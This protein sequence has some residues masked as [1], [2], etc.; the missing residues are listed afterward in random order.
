MHCF[1]WI[2]CLA[3]AA[4]LAPDARSEPRTSSRSVTR[5]E[6]SRLEQKLED[7]QRLIDNLIRLQAQYLQQLLTLFPGTP[8]GGRPLAV[9]P[10]DSK[11]PKPVE[12]DVVAK[13]EG[14]TDPKPDEHR[15]TSPRA[16]SNPKAIGTI[17]GKVKGG[18][19]EAFIYIEDIVATAQGA[20]IMKQEHKQFVPRVLTVPRG[21]KVEFPNADAVFH[22]VFSVTPDNSFDLG[23]YQQG[24]SKGVTMAKSGVVTVYCNMHPQMVG[25]ILVVPSKHYVRAGR[26]GF[27]RLP[28]VP[29]GRHRVVAWAPNT[30]PVTLEVDVGD[31]DSATLEFELK[32]RRTGPHMNKDGMAYGSYKD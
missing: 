29:A 26:D 24:V 19:G 6:I 20:A 1:R 14:Q 18:D 22:N 9:D 23:S 17:V 5:A 4:V 27:Y 21:T 28:N 11:D 15:G 7:Q 12:N 25:Y 31:G 13:A 8:G 10:K 16:R 2:A 30:K 3:V 32:Q